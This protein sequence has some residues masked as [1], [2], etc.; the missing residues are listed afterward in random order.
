MIIINTISDVYFE[1]NE[2]TYAKI[3]QPLKQGAESIGI[4][5]IYNTKQ[6]L[7]NSTPYSEFKIDGI[8]YGT[9]KETIE[10]LLNV[11]YLYEGIIS[12][13]IINNFI[14]NEFLE[15]N[16][17]NNTYTGTVTNAPDEEDITE[18]VNVLKFKDR[19]SGFDNLGYKI[20]RSG[21]DWTSIPV[22][23][24]NSILEIRGEF[25]F[26]G[27]TI[28]IPSNVTLKFNGGK[29]S[30]GTL[31]GDD[32]K[33]ISDLNYIFNSDLTLAGSW[34]LKKVFP[35]WFGAVGDGIS[36]DLTALRNM[37]VVAD[38][39]SG[40]Q[41]EYGKTY[42]VTDFL[43]FQNSELDLNSSE[44]VFELLNSQLCLLPKNNTVVKNGKI[45]NNSTGTVTSG[46]YQ[47]PI[48]VGRF[49]TGESYNNIKL[50]NLEI[51][52]N[53]ANGN[54]IFVTSKSNNITIDNINF[55]DS[56]T[57]GRPIL[58]H[59]GNADNPTVETFHPYNIS[60]NNISCG[61]MSYVAID[62]S[63][64]V[65]SGAYNITV[66]NVHAKSLS[67][68]RGLFFHFAGDYGKYYA[69]S[70]VQ[71]LILKNVIFSNMS[72]ELCDQKGFFISGVGTLAPVNDLLDAPYVKNITIKGNSLDSGGSIV[73]ALNGVLDNI[74][75]SYFKFG[76]VTGSAL[77]GLVIKNSE[78]S[79]SREMGIS[80]TSSIIAPK[81]IKIIG[82]KA[83]M[84]GQDG[85]SDGGIVVNTA[86]NILI[87][88]CILGIEGT[89]TQNWGIRT[90][91]TS[92]NVTIRNN[93]VVNNKAGG[94][95]YSNGSSTNYKILKSF[96]NNTFESGLTGTS[97]AGIITL[98]TISRASLQ[99]RECEGSAAPTS[100]DWIAGE[101][102]FDE[103]PSAGSF[104]GWVCTVSGTAGTWKTFGAIT[105]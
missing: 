69:D 47:C 39:S 40:V 24:A 59:W 51:E 11:I 34:K 83:Y 35:E 82:C 14:T 52:S 94:S 88:N 38:G 5:N 7:Q 18:D 26:S 101:K 25:D 86:D 98:R 92:T 55:P 6:Q 70:G 100:G 3:Y 12:Q 64:V 54:G 4:Y 78:I 56:T 79:Y 68:E 50:Y 81:N 36:D 41:L 60:I 65:V 99:L 103:S 95:S 43:T 2:I 13:E 22:G 71:H 48:L 91:A 57:I 19:D 87:E 90:N 44:I 53:K 15:Q 89:E 73:S 85:T 62:A 31:T 8:V 27:A 80:I 29:F 45:T 37:F 67:Y 58:I 32:T 46:E 30:N 28:T 20:I 63:V 10:A 76:I 75:A 1:L 33:I 61:N 16:I 84:N 97:G 21:F 105:A 74:T 96:I 102:V 77:N 93:H 23:H 66:N 72:A 49:G 17:I 42:K 9:Q 104:I